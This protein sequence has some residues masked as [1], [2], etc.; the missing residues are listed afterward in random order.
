MEKKANSEKSFRG[1]VPPRNV[2]R[3]QRFAAPNCG[4]EIPGS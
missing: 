1:L 4:S 3:D 2:G